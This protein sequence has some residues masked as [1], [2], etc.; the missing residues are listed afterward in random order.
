ML[1]QLLITPDDVAYL[2]GVEMKL[3]TI[4][5]A[6]RPGS[7]QAVRH[8]GLRRRGA[9]TNQR[10]RLNVSLLRRGGH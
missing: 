3:D 7:S 2:R 1:A 4:G 8:A 9:R 5:V 10:A 6:G